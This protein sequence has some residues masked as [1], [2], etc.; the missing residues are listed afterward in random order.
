MNI[1]KFIPVGTRGI[2]VL[3]DP[4]KTTTTDSGLLVPKFENSMSDGGRPV[5]KY[6]DQVYSTMGTVVSISARAEKELEKEEIPVKVGDKVV[7]QDNARAQVLYLNP[8][9]TF[10]THDGYVSIAPLQIIFKIQD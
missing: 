1:E 6:S 9:S 3:L 4:L 5:S 7:I 8:D 2:L 10:S